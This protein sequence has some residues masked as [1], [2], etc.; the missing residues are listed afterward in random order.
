VEEAL[1]IDI[2]EQQYGVL[3]YNKPPELYPTDIIVVR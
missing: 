3:W 2:L 1:G